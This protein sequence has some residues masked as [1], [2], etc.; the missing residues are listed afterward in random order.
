MSTYMRVRDVLEAARRFHRQLKVFF[1]RLADRSDKERVRILLDYMSRHERNFEEGLNEYEAQGSG[2]LLDTWM[3]YGPDEDR[4]EVPSFD[5]LTADGAIDQ[6][7]KAAL[8]FD[9]ALAAFYADAAGRAQNEKV[10]QLFARLAEQHESDKADVR[11]TSLMTR[12][13]A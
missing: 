4:L 2:R 11:K 3:Q 8:R 5:D 1:G 10:R 7:E 12:K 13:G 9:D 6:V